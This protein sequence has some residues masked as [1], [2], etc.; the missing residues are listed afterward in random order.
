MEFTD[1]Y[2]L[3]EGTKLTWPLKLLFYIGGQIAMLTLGFPLALMV[4]GS[5]GAALVL[6][7]CLIIGSIIMT[8]KV[9]NEKL[10]LSVAL[11]LFF[12][13][14]VLSS[15]MLIDH[16]MPK[17]AFWFLEFCVL[18]VSWIF[19]RNHFLRQIILLSIVS[20]FP[21]MFDFIGSF[22]KNFWFYYAIL[23]MV[24]YG[25]T[26]WFDA[27]KFKKENLYAQYIPTL[28]F[29]IVVVAIP[30]ALLGIDNVAQSI[31]CALLSFAVALFILSKQEIGSTKKALGTAL[32]LLGCAASCVTPNVSLAVLGLILTY[33]VSDKF[34]VVALGLF[35][36]Y[37]IGKFYYDMEILLSHKSY[38]LMGSGI[39]FLLLFFFIN[40]LKK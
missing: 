15:S 31:I 20:V 16:E 29:C 22:L 30:C 2:D 4:D 23:L 19:C 34:G 28:R 36:I 39:I 13:G 35:L 25:L 11:P 21:L 26:I 24:I 32:V 18:I 8:R 7:L 12:S 27:D 37:S 14:E 9:D 38:L 5:A 40:R 17:S 1:K 3:T 33:M 10:I 6:G